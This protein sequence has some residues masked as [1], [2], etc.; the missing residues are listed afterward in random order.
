[1]VIRTIICEAA[2]ETVLCVCARIYLLIYLFIHVYTSTHKSLYLNTS[3]NY[4]CVH[5]FYFV[6]IVFSFIS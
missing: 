4:V 1:M 5:M 3:S 6:L 2:L